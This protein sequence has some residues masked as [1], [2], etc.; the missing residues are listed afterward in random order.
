MQI[1]FE[2]STSILGHL[3]SSP[4]IPSLQHMFKHLKHVDI[5]FKAWNNPFYVK[6]LSHL[7]Y[8][9][10]KYAK[11]L[12]LS[13][14]MDLC[15]DRDQDY[16][17]ELHKIYEQRYDGSS[18]WLDFHEHI[19]LIESFQSDQKNNNF[20]EIDYREKG[21]P[22]QTSMQKDWLAQTQTQVCAGD[23]FLCWSEL[24]KSPYMYWLDHEPD[25]VKR[26]C[27]LA[28]PWLILKPR[29]CVALEDNNAIDKKDAHL[30]EAWWQPRKHAWCQHWKLDDWGLHDICGRLIIGHISNLPELISLLHQ[31]IHPKRVVE[32]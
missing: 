20:L 19:H 27:E 26:M 28:K 18:A 6:S 22:L 32:F 17:N 12:G 2:N 29:L 4:V 16:L 30:F 23:I 15:L 11:V 8:D 21:G 10:V 24:G 3:N 31:Q 1:L 7:V 25:D 5:P 13:V 14:S 9:F